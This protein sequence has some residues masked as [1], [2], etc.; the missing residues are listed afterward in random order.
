MRTD[1]IKPLPVVLLENAARFPDKVAF[2]D[3]R[4]AVTHGDLEART[5]RLA[6]HLAALGAA[7]GD[8]V[9]L[10]LGNTVATVESYLA[11]VRAGGIGVP[12]NPASAP[13]ELEYALADSG[14]TVVIT[15]PVGARRLRSSPAV[16][17]ALTL[18]VTGE[19]PEAFEGPGAHAYDRLAVTEPAEPARD[20]LGLDDVAWMFYTSGTTGRPK[21][22]LSTQR[23]C[24][25]SVAS[26][27]VPIPG[28][29][30]QD[31]V[32]W[33]LPLFHSLSHIAC[34]LSVTVVGATAR[35][36]DGASAD[37]VIKALREDD[38]TFLA[39]VPTTYHHLVTAA[40]Q[41]GFSAPALRIGLVGGAVTGPGLRRDFEDTF[42]VPLVDAYG[43]TE[44]CGAITINPPDGARVDGSCGLPVPGV[45]VRVVDP[46]TGL[47]VPAGQDGEV[48]VSGPNVMVGY[49]N[50]PD[51][52][53]EALRD[54]W[55]RTGDL[56]RR[57]DAGYVTIRGRIKEL[58]I[59]GGENIHPEEVEAVLRTVEGVADAAV[60]G[61]PHRTLGEVP[62]AYVVPGASGFATAELLDR[63]RERLAAYKVPERVHEVT[64]IP[65][66][67]S[68]KTR[69]LL[70]ADRPSRLRYAA[71]GH[72]EGLLSLDWAPVAAPAGPRPPA[73]TWAVAG[74]SAAGL[75]TA[76]EAAGAAVRH[77]PDLAAVQTAVAAGDAAPEVTVV[78]R[79]SPPVD[80]PSAGRAGPPDAAHGAI[81]REP[82][83]EG[84]AAARLLA[85][86]LRAWPPAPEPAAARLV[87]LTRA[88]VAATGQDGARDLTEAPLW[89]VARSLQEQGADSLTLLDLDADATP[90]TLFAALASDEPRIA[91]R[92]G[93]LL[94]PRLSRVPVGDTP[95]VA[96][97]TGATGTVV[98]TGAD[99]EHGAALAH[100]LATVH[101]VE[102]L[103]LVDAPADTGTP[104]AAAPAP[105]GTDIVRVAADG[106]DPEPLRAALAGLRRPVSAVVHAAEDPE[107]ALFLDEMTAEAE[108]VPFVAVSGAAALLGT[109]G[110]TDTAVDEALTEAVVHGRRLRGL[111]GTFLA[112]VGGPG[113]AG[114]A[115]EDTGWARAAFLTAFD[116]ALTTDPATLLTLDP[117]AP[118]DVRRLPAPL[119]DLAEPEQTPPRRREPDAAV[120]AALRDRL[121]A[122]DER[123]QQALLEDLVRTRAAAVLHRP[124]PEPIPSDRAF[125]DLGFT[126]MAVVELR[127]RLTESTG[128]PLPTTVVF[129]HPTPEAL[130]ARLRAE[131]LGATRPVTEAALT[132]DP[133]EP[134]AIVGMACRLPGGVTGPEDLWRLVSEGRDAVSGF[135]E[136]RGWDLEGLFDPDPDRAGSSYTDQG[137]FLH[138]AGLFDAGFFGISPREA[139]A[140]DPQQRLLLEASW[141]ALERAGIDP[142]S[143]KG[144]DVG[145][146]S[147]VF[148]QGY[149]AT[150]TGV[151]A[152][153]AE[154]FASTGSAGSVASGRVSYVLGFEGPAVTV[155]TACSSSLVAIH[156]AAQALRQGECSMALAGGATV[157]ATP[158][159]FVEFSRQRALAPDGRCKA[160]SSTADGTG[161]AEGVGVVILERLS[162]ARERGHRVLAVIRG[163]AV[164]QDGASNGLT[165]PNGLSQQRV[166]RR[167]LASAGLASSD[168][169]AVEAHGTGTALGDPIEAQALLATYGQGR[170]PERPLWLGSLKSNIGHAQAAAGVAGVIKMV[171]ALR[172]GLLPATL[173][174]DA[175]TPQVDWSLGAVELL[176]EA[177]DW[178]RDGRPRRAGVSSFGV[179]GTNA[180]LILEEAPEEPVAEDCG[181]LGVVPLV[182]SARSRASLAGQAGRLAAYVE[183][184][185]GASLPAVA[186]A[187]VSGRAVL[188]ERAVVVAGTAEEALT[189]LRALARGEHAAGVVTG[190][191]APGKVV[192]VFPG[193]GSQWVGMGREL[194]DASPV[195][196]ERVGECAA[197]LE[198]WVEWS[199]VD[200]LRGDADPEVFERVDVVQPASFAVMVGLA[201]VWES[202]GVRPDAV[203]GHSQGEIAAACVAGALS[204]EDA[205]RVV[206]LRS[207]AIA[208]ELAGRGGMA[209]VALSEA[210]A[211]ARLESWAGRVEVAA[212]NGPSSVVIAG[213]AQALDEVLEALSGDGVRTRRVAVDY[214]SH[215]RHVEDIQDV[216][217]E[218][219][220]GVSAKAPDVPFYSTV[221]GGWIEEAGVLDGEYWY[222]NLRGQVRFGP[223][224]ADLL[225]EGHGVFV[226]VSAHPVLVQ[227]VTEAVEADA[228]V[229]GSLRRDEGG[230]RRLLVSMA[231]LFVRGVAV[232]WRGVLPTMEATRV[233][234]PTY[235]FEHQHYWLKPVAE[236]TDAAS[237]GQAAA[238]HPLLGAVVAMPDSG[239]LMATSRW[240]LRSQPWLGDQLAGDVAVVPNAALVEVAVRLGDLVASPVLD[241]LVVEEPVVLSRRGSRGVQVV[242]GGPDGPGRRSVEVYSRAGD[243]PLDARWTRH[244]YGTLSNGTTTEVTP[245]RSGPVTEVALDGAALREAGRYGVHPALLDAAVR[246]VVPDGMVASVWTG[247]TLLASGATA[248]HARAAETS[249]D[250]TGLRLTDP[251]GQPVMTVASVRGAVFTPEQA[252]VAAEAARDAL[253]RVDWTELTL[254]AVDR[255]LDVVTVT[256][257]EDVGACAGPDTSVPEVLVY[258]ATRA[259][260]D[261]RPSVN[262]AL[263]VLQAW[264]AEPALAGTRLAVVTGDRTELG[265]AAVGGLVRSAQSEHPGRIVLVELDDDSRAALPAAM[266]SG[267]PQLR[268]RGGVAAA[269]R[270]A[271]VP[272][273]ESGAGRQPRPLD[274]EGTVLITGGT[275]TLGAATARHLVTA[276]GVRHL[277]LA[278]RRG[279]APELREELA[280][281]GASVTVA[282]CDTA[283]RDQ[284]AELLRAIPAERPLTAV[285]HAAGVLD[286]GVLTELTP[287]RV[288]TVLRPKT[289]AALHLHELTR[290]LDLAAFV[291]FS[292]A[293]GVLGN[294][295]QANYAAANAALDA[296]ACQRRRAG[297][298]GV[299]LAWGYWA[300]A[301]GMTAHLGA[302]DLRR[303]QRVGMA[304][305]SAAEGMAL[306]DAALRT[307]ADDPLVA[308]KFDMAALRTAA[309]EGPLPPLLRGLAPRPRPTARAAAPAG[310][311]S[312][313]ERVAALGATERTE[314]LVDLVLGHAAEVLGHTTADAVRADRTFKEAGFDSL[315][316]VELRN[317]LAAATGLTLSP[318]LV[319]DYPKPTALAGHLG[320]ELLGV[321]SD[322]PAEPAAPART[323]DEPIAIVAM[324]CRF[325]AG[326]HSPEDLWR[327]VAEGTDAVT[328]FPDD[329]GWD[330]DRLFHPDPDHAGTTYVR[331]GAFLDD[332]AGFDAAFFGISPN[333]ALAMDPQQRLLLETSWE[334]FERAAIDPATLAGQDVGVFVG[335]NSHDYSV[336][337][338]RAPGAAGIEGLRLTGGSGSV[339]SGRV[340][341]HFG[342]E[343]PAITVD[344]ACSSSLVALHMAA[345]ALHRGECSMAL[346]GG[347]MVMGTVETFVEFS[348]QRGLAPD[349]RCKAFADGADGTGWSEGVGLLLV[350][351]LSDARRRG[352]QVLAVVRGSAVNQDGASNGL[353]APNG[354]AQQRVIRK[355]L[356]HAGLGTS[357]V[358]AVEAHGTG[359]ALGDPIEAQALL[360]TYGQD[361]PAERPL[362]LGSVK[363]NIGHTQAAAGVAGV[364]K[365]VMAMRHGTLPRTLHVDRPSSR[366][367]WSAG[368]VEL[369][370]EAREWPR[371]GR[372]RRAG[373]SS[374]GIGG[375]NA[376]VVLEEAPESEARESEVRDPEALDSEVSGQVVTGPQASGRQ[377]P[378]QPVPDHAAAVEPEPGP[379]RADDPVPASV[380]VPASAPVP[381]LV[382]ARTPDG[383][384]GQAD[385]LARFLDDR[386]DVR[387]ADAAHALATTRARLDHRAVVL[388]SDRGQAGADLR[389][390]GR[391]D[392]SPAVVSGTPVPGK[393]AVLFTGQ[394]SQWPGMGRALAAAHPVFRDAFA[395]ACAAVEAHLGGHAARPLHEVVFAEHG[396][397]GSELLGRTMYTQGALFALET[398]LFRLFESWGVRPDLLAGHSIGEITAAHV[399]GVLG[400]AEAGELV[401]A[402]GRLMQ[403]LPA[404]GAMVAVRATEADVEPLLARARGTVCVAA[405][406][407]PD[408][409]VLSGTEDAVLALADELACQ[410]RKTRRLPVRHA[411]HSPLM[412][413][414]LDE[415]RTVAERLSYRTGELPVVST[416]TGALARDGRLATPGYWVD[417][418]RGTVRFG[419]A[420]TALGGLGATTF[421]ELGPGGALAAMALG[422]LGTPERSC[423]ATLRK[424]GAEAADVLTALAELHVRGTAVDWTAVL[425]P[426][427]AAAGADL[428]TYAFQHQRYWVDSDS[429]SAAPAGAEAL[430]ATGARHPLLGTVIDVP[431]DGGGSGGV[432][433]TGRL[434]PHGPGRLP[435][436]E[437]ADGTTAIPAAVLL[438][439]LVRAGDE[440]G[441]GSLEQIAV[442]EPLTVPSRGHTHVRVSVAAPAPDGR[443]RATVHGRPAGP[444]QG[445]WTCHARAVLV[446]GTPRPAFDLRTW[447]PPEDN[448]ALLDGA[449]VWQQGDHTCAEITLPSELADEAGRFTLHPVLLDTALR[450]LAARTGADPAA[451]ADGLADC[452]GLAVYAE[453]ATSL[454]LR[455]TP[456]RDGRHLLELADP[457]GEPV[458]AL[459]PLS[460]TAPA[461]RGA[462]PA[463]CAGGTADA[464]AATGAVA[465]RVVARRE[466]AD[467][468]LADRLAGLSAAEQHRVVLDLVQESTAVV[469]GH[470]ARDRFDE[471]QPFKN[472]GFDSLGAVRLRNRLRDFTGVELSSTLVFD[473]P[474]PALLAAFLRAELLGERPDTPAPAP[475]ASADEPIAIV[476]MSSRL[477]GGA[478][479]PEELWTLL[480]E[481]RDA[482]SGFP[483]DRDWDLEGLYHPD[484]SHP[485]TSYTRS[486]GFLHEAARFDAGL[487]GISPREA[488]AMDPQQ[489]L[490][491]ET[492]W[493]ALE[494]AG[495][496]PLSAR[497]GDIGVFTG[498]V[499]HD[500]VT[501][502]H[503]VPEDVQGYLMT[504]TASSVASG[505]VSYVFGFEGPA[506]TVDTACSSSLVAMHLAAQA[507]R[508]GECSMALAGGATVMASPDAFLEFSRQRGLSADGRCK[509][510]SST[511]DGTGWSEGV[512]V[513]VLERLSV[514]RERGHQVLAVIRGSA[515]NQDGA[516]NGLTAPNGP[517]QQR[518]IRRALDTAGLTPADVDVVEA[519]GT[520]TA[521]GDPIE[522]QALLATYGQGR[523]P[524]QPLWLG[525]LKSNIGHTQ[526][527][528]GVAGVIKMVMALRHGLMPPT[529]HVDEPTTEVDWSA[530]AVELL[531]EARAWPREGRPRRAGVSAFGASGTNAHL[532]LEEAPG[533]EERPAPE[534]SGV[535]PLVVSARS[536]GSL[537]GQ[538]GRLASY[539]E[540]GAAG[541]PLAGVAGALASGRA[542]LAER[543]VVV[544][545][546]PAEAL[547]GL[548]ALAR[549]EGAPNVVTG[550]ATGP[551]TP[552][553]IVLV[554]PGQGAQWAGMGRELLATSAVF[555]ER[556]GECAAAL[557]RWVDW[558]LVDVLRGEVE[559]EVLERVDVVQPASFAVMVGLAAV[560]ASV[561]VRPDAVLGHSQGEIAAA[562]VAGALSLD[563]AAR[564]VALRSQAI[565]T[566]LAGRGGMASV[567]LGEEDAAARL[568]RWAGRVEVAA[569]N[570]P[571]SVVV[572]GDAHAL[573]E[574]LTALDAEGVRTRRVAVD[575][576]S[577]SRHVEDIRA[578]LAEALDGVNAKAPVVPFHSTVTGDRVVDPE[579]LDGAYWYRNLRGQVRFGPA[580][581]ELLRQGHGVFVEVSAH[582]VLVQPVT[583]AVDGADAEAVV[584]GSLRREDGGPRRLLASMAELFV[585]GVAVDWSAVLPAGAAAA[586]RSARADLPTYAFD[587]QHYWLRE[588]AAD[589]DTADAAE[590]ADADFWAAVEHADVDSLGALLDTAA[591]DQLGALNTLVPVLAE[592]RG[593]RRRMS[594]AERLRYHVTWQ[595]LAHEAAGVPGGRWLVVV[596]A[597]RTDDSGTDALLA[598]LTGLGLTAVPLEVGA[599]DGTRERLAERLGAV[600]AE[601]DVTGVL[602]LLALDRGA[603]GGPQDPAA[604]TASSLALIQALG[605]TGATPP[606]WC[607]TRGAVNIGIHDTLTSPA[608][609]ALWG[610]GR[611]AALERP[612][613]WGGLIDLPAAH[614]PRTARQLLG[615]LNS[616]AGEDQLAVRRSGA[617]ARRLVRKAAPDTTGDSGWQPRGTVLVTGGA[618]GLGRH[619]SLWLALAGVERLLVTTTAHAPD[620]SVP[621]LRAEL[622]ASDLPAV[623]ETC[624]DT[625]RDALARLLAAKD[626]ERPL[627]AVV[628]AADLT[629]TSAV[630]DTGAHDLAEVFAAK[631]DTAVWLDALFED[632][633]LDAFVVFSSIAGV[634]GGGGQGPSGAANAVLDALVERRRARG[635]RA[636]SIAWGALDGIGVGMDEAA[637]A[638]LRRRGV[639][640]MA[641][642]LAVTAMAQAVR[643]N[644]KSVTVADMDWRA[645]VPAF[646]SVRPSPLLADLPEAQAV[647]Q[648]A[649]DDGQ[650]SGTAA[651]LADSL[652]AVSDAERN[653][654]LLRLVRGHA[655]TV[656]GHGGAEGIGPRQAFQDVGFDSLAAVNL[657]NS[658]HAAT[659]LRLPATLI[660]DYPTP[661][662]LVGHLR[663]ELLREPDDG[664]AGR[665]DD[666]RRVLASVPLA[667]FREAGVLDALLGLAEAETGAGA[668]AT[669]GPPTAADAELID[670]MDVAGLVQRA[671]GKTS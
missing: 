372:P 24:L 344:T 150:G 395:A 360:A 300:K 229:T 503:Q 625:D 314:A 41:N 575:Y 473:H 109:P 633:P 423:V 51:A 126:S 594:T 123:A 605:D 631:V 86:Q 234:L 400:L 303:N 111:P 278:S 468:T 636:T 584:T 455:F 53:A 251:T 658:L 205:A 62:V 641:P 132:A 335:V 236:A 286:D 406:N 78:V 354:P 46:G 155:D 481:G 254:P 39:G 657:R 11:V 161:W 410:G 238:D 273:P 153:E 269:P 385:R 200:V 426:P 637:L 321:P 75:A 529:L 98:V 622:A 628:H 652:R 463:S 304:G 502:L 274:P 552:G 125:R 66:T 296:L 661:E 513:V 346:A 535:V 8:R 118:A 271:R 517:S 55:Y 610:L 104:S 35:L 188:G 340:A 2:E 28:L 180:H 40:R 441:C 384:R 299:S 435:G 646:T 261:P 309:A 147:G 666:L 469:L 181:P 333:E 276:H 67:A 604:V 167:A 220:A 92:S 597:G 420:V 479:S 348:R 484:P 649:G 419:D 232:D 531:T 213:D 259:T 511:A 429:D 114:P 538:A 336:R 638:Q 217:A 576:A 562:C 509:A 370:T 178:P 506:V 589:D 540:S 324:A 338:H 32:L 651:S 602:S 377:V 439:M 390:F 396:A 607:L 378:G 211:V 405:V 574:A 193:Q 204:L 586:A 655:S 257:A 616:A 308:A 536:A 341:Y 452:A 668:R 183:S 245:P 551:G 82:V 171:Q 136:D 129:D 599:A 342:F 422:T 667:R 389:A 583:E 298:P 306:L 629:W 381:V 169:D 100:R 368:A 566:E 362:W 526:A 36:L 632:T 654:L 60:S 380:P 618:E 382:S 113:A 201:A 417:Q 47:D 116:L 31:R 42:G 460:L 163:S 613:R 524:E 450:V 87:V 319:F 29:T 175:P 512:G 366:I 549:G 662:A 401:A 85:G 471:D 537:A 48:W 397:P 359:T 101:Q 467:D 146:Y 504:G 431:G 458:A 18:L 99:T 80:A 453:G 532:I 22:V 402:R 477:P 478:D 663:T 268:V 519:H 530:G 330:T 520:G 572:A 173:H 579:V 505:R 326:A 525:S 203:L 233:E 283:D 25:W 151:V 34:V 527:A 617:Y 534:P 83:A 277:V 221:T 79:P 523:E 302:A 488:L 9:A 33:P 379:R 409:L 246:T 369:L 375:T 237:L 6:G 267:E 141:E 106:R 459:G 144:A 145:V 223:A 544:A 587:H 124:G 73:R 361:R 611:A 559:P 179:S 184:G 486:G 394:G 187:L 645:F 606:L 12:L 214:A 69:R 415:F 13:A 295:G 437:G 16:P 465:R 287:E 541:V 148:G 608:Q 139:L 432:V 614:G 266:L 598:E 550:S 446:P 210:T 355:A 424:D 393:L 601:H 291:L 376:H 212:V 457:D 644:E 480:V 61:A 373:V 578:T 332:A 514:A 160:F 623:V 156:L 474:T 265:A 81:A 612:D 490:L 20:D 293:A 244:A 143:L 494:R 241:E 388:A 313:R 440:V 591:A 650:D 515:V 312:L 38:T 664:L 128:L 615:V 323:A 247:V 543:A 603:R 7:R 59:R 239:G 521:L 272:V 279:A 454:R 470:R 449:R 21:G 117:S 485:G 528:A 305:L 596:P 71:S 194:L 640:P 243:A 621:E 174:V 448:T 72:H 671:L 288:D 627:T 127:N 391:G 595:P 399:S 466:G 10:C 392:E 270:L 553:K 226:E 374:F 339:A 262:A 647:L 495:V 639:L 653:R 648:A 49:H 23:N 159:T 416:L 427:A 670:A 371:D 138:E 182:V 581:S 168:V 242:V 311:A 56:A 198:R 444:E 165:A 43:S 17:P 556:V 70:L 489:R 413:P 548:H 219:L 407:G 186:G 44:T 260:T 248:L 164:N 199:L 588:A 510:F 451:D 456:G 438:D 149:G 577:H 189:G 464:P 327:V 642:Q 500:Y 669:T 195:F 325:P 30:D 115:D 133:G 315:T 545:D 590:G 225:R 185:A 318:A 404:D 121:A 436:P 88:A 197:A 425:A 130:A 19:G 63:C 593:R 84:R 659:G 166:I 507:L 557:E 57:D 367:D 240:S 351:R 235:A 202:V 582:P 496:D 95:G 580:V 462:A 15:D 3:D 352:H 14:A 172:H 343:G 282:A 68:G 412:E 263:A 255:A 634:W 571:S 501:R 64:A 492:S 292:S 228:V 37:D 334:A 154:G 177:R 665:E 250:G 316:A 216:L 430:G 218:A 90:E 65:R 110:T 131:I 191:G 26:C 555:A 472:L 119:A 585:R 542:A 363:S 50:S 297:L 408:A 443:R 252:G 563:D 533:E 350:E 660:F 230:L 624:A 294:P 570:S 656:L 539:V 482:I 94:A 209:S 249:A 134:L 27:Y 626:P 77:Y 112:R 475:A 565:A 207:Q 383:L 554:F 356:A 284:V 619:V 592:W 487:F 322:R 569:V 122:L 103:L 58:V 499:H 74:P 386:P 256:G 560:W 476:A 345:Q 89:A 414:M 433:L 253:F 1:L 120:T 275:G 546:A 331:H 573:D 206:A 447:Q 635:L 418:V 564:V 491:L 508:Q 358:D 105:T 411:F 93:A 620:G 349:G 609:A 152:P 45:G 215:T 190:T 224:V 643:G 108:P 290:D 176:T 630:D 227:P 547:A 157:M 353:T 54:G 196:A 137:G 365:M 142:G 280:A 483:V 320:A 222:R 52:T 357:D 398:A 434:A 403:A 307:G 5:R 498:I 600:L 522:A 567:A 461:G 561:G 158:G 231:E 4:R 518:V 516:S 140:M 301:S 337:L 329:R 493:E 364:I 310:P 192:W 317:R 264:L 387:L 445:P 421:L 258:E 558:S 328:E 96:A 497:G 428:P 442:Q 285:V 162:V 135:P 208:G 347:V 107:L 102:H 568:E 97:W 76:L 281:L 170:E 91:V 289:D